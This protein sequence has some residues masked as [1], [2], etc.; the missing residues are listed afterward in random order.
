V[1][2]S[3]HP[4]LAGRGPTALRSVGEGRATLNHRT[5]RTGFISGFAES[6]SPQPSPC[7]GEGAERLRVFF[8]PGYI[9]M[10][11]VFGLNCLTNAGFGCILSVK[12]TLSFFFFL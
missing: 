12:Q 4:S 6:P 8:Y 5:V 10:E 11:S 9:C 7:Q 2:V 3:V 1:F